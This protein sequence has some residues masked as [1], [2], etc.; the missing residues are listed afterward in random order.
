MMKLIAPILAALACASTEAE[1]QLTW[2][3]AAAP[4]GAAAWPTE[5]LLRAEFDAL[6]ANWSKDVGASPA[7]SRFRIEIRE[8]TGSRD[9]FAARSTWQL[10]QGRIE[11]SSSR[12]WRSGLR[13]EMGHLFLREWRAR[14]CSP[15]EAQSTPAWLDEIESLI[16]SED[17]ASLRERSAEVPSLSRARQQLVAAWPE[18]EKFVA[19]VQDPQ[20]VAAVSRLLL[21]PPNLQASLRDQLFDLNLELGLEASARLTQNRPSGSAQLPSQAKCASAAERAVRWRNALLQLNSQSSELRHASAGAI[22]DLEYAVMDLWSGQWLEDS[23]ESSRVRRPVASILKPLLIVAEPE[24]WPVIKSQATAEWACPQ[25]Q[26]P[27]NW[28]WSE[29]LAKS[30]NGYFLAQARPMPLKLLADLDWLATDDRQREVSVP[31]SMGLIPRAR[32]DLHSVLSVYRALALHHPEV[33]DELRETAKSGTLSGLAESAKFVERGWALKTGTT[34]DLVGAPDVGWIVGISDSA[35]FAVRRRGTRPQALARELEKLYQ[36]WQSQSLLP[37]SAAIETQ[38]LALVDEAK[39]EM[40]CAGPWSIRNRQ[41]AKRFAATEVFRPAQLQPGESAVCWQGAWIAS[42]PD[43]KSAARR[44]REVRGMIIKFH[45]TAS[46]DDAKTP[47]QKAT[48]KQRRARRGTS[49]GLV[50]SRESY[51]AESLAAELASGPREAQLALAKV[52]AHNLLRGQHVSPRHDVQRLCDS[53]H[54]QVFGTHEP[55]RLHRQIAAQALREAPL[56]WAGWLEFSRGGVEAWSE[57]VAPSSWAQ[58]WPE[59]LK[60]EELVFKRVGDRAILRSADSASSTSSASREKSKSALKS[61]AE[62]SCEKLRSRLRLRRCPDEVIWSQEER[63]FI[64]RGRGEGHDRGMNVEEALHLAREGRTADEI[65]KLS[66][67]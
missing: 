32:A 53:T 29:A 26:A 55:T 3:L 6:W 2:Q 40:T 64:V 13:H 50:T 62:L 61:V 37:S 60:L 20:W 23:G 57:T 5:D 8:L 46:A 7:M 39:I 19:S 52:L 4:Q 12:P 49:L 45:P 30:C 51:V 58:A 44:T 11:L 43:A 22:G 15:S 21:G 38:L 17:E 66:Y 18:A 36:Q 9:V 14:H 31:E 65:L 27:R 41:G 48:P 63:A 34:R 56:P 54:C 67:D 35:V 16:W 10:G 47:E 28:T 33:R 24:S 42:M 25:M 1:A 59:G